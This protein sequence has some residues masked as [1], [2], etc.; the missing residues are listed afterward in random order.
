MEPTPASPS[1]SAGA[2]RPADCE[3]TD[4]GAREDERG[5]Q[6][7]PQDPRVG[8]VHG[9]GTG[10]IGRCPGNS[11]QHGGD[12]TLPRSPVALLNTFAQL[13]MSF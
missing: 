6:N 5:S 4:G 13:P 10:I 11:A 7:N 2:G 8:S 12:F 3:D 9:H 1:I